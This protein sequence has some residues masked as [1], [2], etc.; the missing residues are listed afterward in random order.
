MKK[1]FLFLVMISFTGVIFSQVLFTY[2]NNPVS[3]E[4][5]L[6]AYNKNKTAV[7]DKDKALRDYLDLYIRFKLKVKAAQE[8]H[9]D[10][11]VTLK[12]DLQNF[13][14]QIEES[15]MNDQDE[16]DR[17]LNEAFGRSQKDIHISHMFIPFAK[18]A[19]PAD[20]LKTYNAM[21]LAYKSLSSD[22]NSFG[23]VAAQLQQ[24]GLGV[25]SD[26]LGFI[27]AFSLP[28]NFE[29]LVYKLKPSEVSKPYR[30]ISGYHIFQNIEERKAVGKI[31]AAQILIAVPSGA[32]SVDKNKAY[33]LA[34]S[35]YQAVKAGAD[36]GEMAKA[37]SN[38]K[39]TY[40]SGGTLPEFGV[41]KYDAIFE[42]KAFSLQKNGDITFPFETSFGYHIIKR[43]SVSRV[44]SDKNDASFMYALKQQVL[45]DD[46][47]SIAKA[48]FL[49]QVLSR[50]GY[51]KN[52]SINEQSLWILTDS[53]VVANKK[54][55]VGNL[56]AKSTLH[57][58]N[59]GI[60]KVGDWLQFAHDYKSNSGLYKGESNKVLME[61]YI[62]LTA[63]EYYRKRLEEFDPNF[64]YQMQEFKEGNLLFEIMERNVWSKASADSIG[65]QNY[66]TEHKTKYTWNVSADAILFSAANQNVASNAIKS[67]NSGQSWKSVMDTY[68]AQLQTDSGRYELSQI[69]LPKNETV[70]EGLISNPVLND[71]DGTASFVKILKLYPANQQ[72][73][74]EEARG[75]VIND[76]QGFIE[77][78]WIKILRLAYP[79][80]INEAVFSSV[81]R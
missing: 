1:F 37:M 50:T 34:D 53:F 75:L 79:V 16:V 36:F 8:L 61:K 3:K 76:Y 35:I 77:E 57:S 44:P 40:M 4:E 43:M 80:R 11:L 30:T 47:I 60:V 48:K 55:S 18:S 27:S 32:G 62:A 29:T 59:K 28:Y 74:F 5:F 10:T 63:N 65:L 66:Y 46:R 52:M 39:M 58:F 15:Y 69:P 6:R 56:D 9:L 73:K 51:K 13:R 42:S 24:Q 12:S 45:S 33:R 31:K 7:T 68:P 22:H 23:T 25:T 67:L 21:K 70:K 2:G 41:G 26:D 81:I 17:L 49:K 20:T 14:T 71:A 64:R 78:R 72:R 19:V 38:D 54:I